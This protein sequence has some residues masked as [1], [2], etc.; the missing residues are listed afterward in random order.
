MTPDDESLY[1]RH[2]AE[3]ERQRAAVSSDHIAASI[4]RQLADHYRDRATRLVL[5]H[6]PVR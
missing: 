6:M 1:L 2:R 4:H 5:P 3:Q